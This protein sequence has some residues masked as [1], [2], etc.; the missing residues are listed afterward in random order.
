MPML[1]SIDLE[2]RIRDGGHVHEMNTLVD[3]GEDRVC[4]HRSLCKN[5]SSYQL[6]GIYYIC[7]PTSNMYDGA[8]RV[9][10]CIV[11]DRDNGRKVSF[12]STYL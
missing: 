5:T 11:N 6:T 3:V 2:F 1:K 10:S 9:T 12:L 7:M 8:I 4:V